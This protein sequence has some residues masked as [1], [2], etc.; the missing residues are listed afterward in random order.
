MYVSFL[1]HSH[2]LFVANMMAGHILVKLLSGCAWTMLALGGV[3]TAASL[4]PFAM[5]FALTGLE[6]GVACFQAYVLTILAHLVEGSQPSTACMAAAQPME[7]GVHRSGC[8]R[9]QQDVLP[10]ELGVSLQGPPPDAHDVCTML[11]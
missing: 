5:S 11:L 10:V 8:E 6:I 7:E 2:Q 1:K 4:K 9:G 3:L